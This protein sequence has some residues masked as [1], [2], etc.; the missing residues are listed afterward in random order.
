MTT[1]TLCKRLRIL[2]SAA[3]LSLLATSCLEGNGT[4]IDPCAASG[5][6]SGR[7]S[8][9]EAKKTAPPPT[10]EELQAHRDQFVQRMEAPP[11]APMKIEH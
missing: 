7:R 4:A 1:S 8:S 3:T 11:P 6:S 2:L 10:P 9:T 5:S